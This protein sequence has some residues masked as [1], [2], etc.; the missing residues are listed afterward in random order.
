[1]NDPVQSLWIG[2]Q[3][4]TLERLSIQSFLDH[5]HDYRLYAYRELPDLPAGAVLMDAG[6]LMPAER[7]FQYRD[8]PSYAAFANVFRYKLLLER[9]GW[10]ADTDV[11]CLR[12]FA[13]SDAQV[14]PSETVGWRAMHG[15]QAVVTSCVLKAAPGSAAMA[16]ALSVCLGKDWTTIGWGEIGP[17]L[18]A[19]VV[20]AQALQ[21][22]VQPPEAFCPIAYNDWRQLID[23][24]PPSLPA[25]SYA[26]HFWNEMWRLAGLDK[27][28]DYPPS[29]LYESLKRRHLHRTDRGSGAAASHAAGSPADIRGSAAPPGHG[30]S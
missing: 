26:V 23:P 25:D 4:S 11:V 6:E 18:V 28:A 14:F 3:L 15:P 20:E 1:M 16:L 19:Q 24:H 7:I 21:R 10:W 9:G 5:G 27:N 30:P 29:C 12:P 8:R 17:R 13:L 22:F 2:T